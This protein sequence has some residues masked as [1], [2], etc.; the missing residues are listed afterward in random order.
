MAVIG[1]VEPEPVAYDDRP[2]GR[3]LAFGCPPRRPLP[4]RPLRVDLDDP[5]LVGV[6]PVDEDLDLGVAEAQVPREVGA[7]AD[8]SASCVTARSG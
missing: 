1:L 5:G 2:A 7:D 4:D 3:I 6:G 8:E